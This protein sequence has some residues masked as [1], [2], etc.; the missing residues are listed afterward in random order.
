[1]ISFSLVIFK[2]FGQYSSSYFAEHL[3]LEHLFL[4]LSGMWKQA[5]A[6]IVQE[7]NQKAK[8]A[9]RFKIIF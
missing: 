5:I 6:K 8:I 3:L 9:R 7:K 2:N 4:K 1:M